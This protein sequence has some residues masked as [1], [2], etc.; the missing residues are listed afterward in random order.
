MNQLGPF[1]WSTMASDPGLR[2]VVRGLLSGMGVPMPIFLSTTFSVWREA[3]GVDRERGRECVSERERSW[4]R[5]LHLP[6]HPNSRTPLQLYNSTPSC[7][8]LQLHNSTVKRLYKFRVVG[9]G[10]LRAC[11]HPTTATPSPSRTPCC[12]PRRTAS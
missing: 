5:T 6:S 7:T 3:L 2:L 9:S 1:P 8:T 4:S 12:R 10:F 11:R